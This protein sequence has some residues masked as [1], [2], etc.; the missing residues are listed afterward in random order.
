MNDNQIKKIWELRVQHANG[1]RRLAQSRHFIT[2]EPFFL[3]DMEYWK[4]VRA[5][6]VK[7]L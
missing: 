4:E 1:Q 6:G 7:R 3:E 5:A 2:N